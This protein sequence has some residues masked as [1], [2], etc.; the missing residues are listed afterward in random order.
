MS[1]DFVRGQRI[2]FAV[3]ELRFEVTLASMD[4][5]VIGAFAIVDYQGERTI[6]R[7]LR[8]GERAF[9]GR[10]YRMISFVEDLPL[11]LIGFLALVADAMAKKEV[12]IFVLSSYRTDHILVLDRDLDR[13]IEALISL[14][15]VLRT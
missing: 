10:A 14:G 13:A 3:H 7:A 6:V 1:R 9:D 15:M 2:R 12:P 5:E 8:H 4:D 11:D